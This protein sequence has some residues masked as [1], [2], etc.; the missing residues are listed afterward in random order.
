MVRIEEVFVENITD[1]IEGPFVI[2]RDMRVHGIITVSAIVEEGIILHLHGMITGDLTVKPGATAILHGMVN[3][4]VNNE[5]GEVEIY[6]KADR[7]IDAGSTRTRID[8]K[9]IIG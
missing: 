3:G 1:K 4:T 6:G 8:P 7:V 2:D 9:A 5:G